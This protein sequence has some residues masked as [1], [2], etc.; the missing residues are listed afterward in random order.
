MFY[1]YKTEILKYHVK[2][3]CVKCQCQPDIKPPFRL[4]SCLCIST[5]PN[6]LYTSITV[7]WKHVQDKEKKNPNFAQHGIWWEI[8][9]NI[10]FVTKVHVPYEHQVEKKM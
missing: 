5:A 4:R 2:K 3:R 6:Q 9:G 8:H 1:R 10:Y 7:W